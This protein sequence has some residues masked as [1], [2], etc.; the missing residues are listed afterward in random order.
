MCALMA[1]ALR[2][3]RSVALI[4]TVL[5]D[6]AGMHGFCVDARSC[7]GNG[8]GS[9]AGADERAF[10]ELS[11]LLLS[12]G[13]PIVVVLDGETS[14]RGLELARCVRYRVATER[15]RIRSA[16]RKQPAGPV[17]EEGKSIDVPT[18]FV[19]ARDLLAFKAQLAMSNL[20]PLSAG[21]LSPRQ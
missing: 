19:P 2:E 4:R 1:K 17:G 12:F 9:L 11:G 8:G 16:R 18:H 5:I 10:E 13:K 7:D 3:W 6:H 14:G 20:A 21:S 15:T